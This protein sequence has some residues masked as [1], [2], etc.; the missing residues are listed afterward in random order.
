MTFIE[1]YAISQF[2][3]RI[4]R[5][6]AKKGIKVVG[7]QNTPN[8]ETGRYDNGETGYLLDDNGTGR[9][10]SYLEVLKLAE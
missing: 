9:M 4:V 8:R 1:E 2:G 6:L 7:A 5:K 10:R 3:K